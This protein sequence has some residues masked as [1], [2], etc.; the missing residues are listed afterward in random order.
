LKGVR[1]TFTSASDLIGTK[2]SSDGGIQKE[3]SEPESTRV[4]RRG[5]AYFSQSALKQT[6]SNRKIV[7]NHIAQKTTE[8]VFLSFN[9]SGRYSRSSVIQHVGVKKMLQ[10]Y[11][12]GPDTRNVN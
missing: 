6:I 5:C 2:G 11:C 8:D 7:K 4:S 10:F 9:I 12:K 1:D 3:F